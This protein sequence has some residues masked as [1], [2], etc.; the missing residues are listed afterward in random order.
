MKAI[1]FVIIVSFAT[2]V[3]PVGQMSRKISRVITI[4]IKDRES[5]EASHRISESLGDASRRQPELLRSLEKEEAGE[6]MRQAEVRGERTSRILG[7]LRGDRREWEAL[8]I[9]V[10]PRMPGSSDRTDR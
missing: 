7:R 3:S 5:N 9:Q 6:A 4:Q 2:A 8:V 10:L 1:A